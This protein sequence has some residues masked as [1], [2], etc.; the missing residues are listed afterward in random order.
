MHLA[1]NLS[2]RRSKPSTDEESVMRTGA[3]LIAA[4]LAALT[5]AL[6]ASADE[7][8]KNA[9][10]CTAM[11]DFHSDVAT[12]RA[13]GPGST[14]AALKEASGRVETDAQKVL[15]TAGKIDTPTA[16]QFTES[17]HQ[18]RV[19]AGKI[20]ESITIAQAQSRIQGDVQD[21]E[22][23]ARQLATEAGCPEAAPQPGTT[24]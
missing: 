17:A 21:V 2:R 13:L 14:V 1:A 6:A 24:E 18:L 5:T 16:K 20:P 10:F 11:T 8:K 9:K 22:R 12:L 7:A 4:G 15:K 23:A 3:I 19:D